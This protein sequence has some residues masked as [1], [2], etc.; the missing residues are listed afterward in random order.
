NQPDSFVNCSADKRRLTGQQVVEDRAEAVNI[1]GACKLGNVAGSL[2]GRHITRRAER[3]YHRTRNSTFPFNKPRQAKIG[4]MRLAVGIYQD[5]PRLN[6]TMQDTA[7]MSIM[8]SVRELDN[9][10]RRTP[11]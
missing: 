2:F 10:F 3:S 1:S 6:I 5:V 9:Q 4:K 7:L 8:N 11:I